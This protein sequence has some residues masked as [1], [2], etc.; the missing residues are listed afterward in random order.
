MNLKCKIFAS[1]VIELSFNLFFDCLADSVSIISRVAAGAESLC[2]F[3]SGAKY[4][5][6]QA[7][8]ISN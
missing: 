6:G 4:G 1:H 7:V 3:S 8:Q 5:N 2:C